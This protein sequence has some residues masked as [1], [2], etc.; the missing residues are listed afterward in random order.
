MIALVEKE[1]AQKAAQALM[2]AGAKK[3]IITSVNP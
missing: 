3:T 1:S 2:N